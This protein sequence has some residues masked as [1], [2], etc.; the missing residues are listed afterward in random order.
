MLEE[1][2]GIR[3]NFRTETANLALFCY[4]LSLKVDILEKENKELKES[5]I[6]L[7]EYHGRELY[8]MKQFIKRNVEPDLRYMG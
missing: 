5:L 2:I 3:Q 6:H 8:E 7:Q 4:E 1:P